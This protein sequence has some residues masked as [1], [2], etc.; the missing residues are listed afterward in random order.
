M[1]SVAVAGLI[2]LAT[3]WYVDGD[4]SACPG[5]GSD[6]APYCTI[7]EAFDNPALAAGDEILVRDAATPYGSAEIY[8]Q[9]GTSADPI[10]LRPDEGHAPI[11]GGRLEI[12]GSSHW[13]VRGFV[14]A[15][16]GGAATHSALVAT[17][18]SEVV[19]GFVIEGNTF[20][21]WSGPLVTDPADA[22]GVGVIHIAS[23]PPSGGP[24][25]VGPIVRGNRILGGR[26]KGISL[27]NVSG[28]T[29]ERNEITDLTCQTEINGP[30][31]S[32]IYVDDSDG[33]VVARNRIRDLDATTCPLG[34]DLRVIGVWV[35]SSVSV[36]VHHNLVE[37]MGG[38]S[39]VGMGVDLIHSSN[40]AS[41][42]HNIVVAADQCGLC[43]GTMGSNGGARVRFV[44]NTVIG[45]LGSGLELLDG[46]DTE[47]LNNVVVGAGGA[48]ARIL[49]TA[50][51]TWTFD[52]NVY[53]PERGEDNVGRFDYAAAVDFEAWQSGCDC[54]AA[55]ILADP[56]LPPLGTEDFTPGSGSPVLDA[57][58]V[59]PEADRFNGRA[60]DIGAVE[61]PIV[62]GAAIS[63]V[64]PDLIR[65][66]LHSE[67]SA[68]RY[69]PGCAGFSITVDGAA[70]ATTG[71]VL[72]GDDRLLVR[73]G[74]TVPAGAQVGLAYEGWSLGN[75]DAIGGVVDGL[76]APFELVV[77]N[78]SDSDPPP[79]DGD[80]TTEGDGT[81]DADATGG[82]ITDG[83][84]M[85]DDPSSGTE[86]A[87]AGDYPGLSG[88]GCMGQPRRTAWGWWLLLVLFWRRRTMA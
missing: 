16:Q 22:V 50:V 17:T 68:L 73:L 71:C 82:A 36:E 57:G 42:H 83:P 9:D 15:A 65:L 33:T 63:A 47:F 5:E 25:M 61:P 45:G 74:A 1:Y 4:A 3:P 31:M 38:Q 79:S 43:N 60:P 58:L 69:D 55:T 20:V 37:R 84:P 30:G 21:G 23:Y 56:L 18:S 28:A 12:G 6:A 75:S 72:D 59:E 80:G 46:E 77:D 24:T 41:I 85:D 64:E 49:T 8:G 87:G 48:Q 52:H 62:V 19:E 67:T 78:G 88:C 26:G 27:A 10:V 34:G 40:D 70:A 86:S 54:D 76:V 66:D 32:G 53:L 29:L 14:F 44:N 7:Q 51:T 13:T 35:Q 2:W 11:V 81:G 39:G